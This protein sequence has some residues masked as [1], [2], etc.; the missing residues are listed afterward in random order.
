[1]VDRITI[2]PDKELRKRLEDQ[3]KKDKRSL[4]N[5]IILILEKEVRK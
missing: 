4:N 5:L 2:Y 3:A 1:M